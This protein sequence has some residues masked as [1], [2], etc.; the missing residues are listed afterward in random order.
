VSLRI[1]ATVAVLALLS[2]WSSAQTVGL[3]RAVNDAMRGRPGSA[4]VL[5]VASGRILAARN[6][7]GAAR[8][9]VRPGSTVKPFTLLA[10]SSG[11][12]DPAARFFCKRNLRVGHHKLDC[13]HPVIPQG[14]DA[15]GALAYSCN[16]YFLDRGTGPSDAAPVAGKIFATYASGGH[17]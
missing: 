15:V 4:V 7:A 2:E 8:R 17:S 12:V 9:V 1:A 13:G 3:Q 6:L 14:L 5:D 10:L 16:D 11:G